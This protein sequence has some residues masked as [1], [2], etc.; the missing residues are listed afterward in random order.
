MRFL[1][2]VK[3]VLSALDNCQEGYENRSSFDLYWSET[4]IMDI[5]RY[6]INK[7][8]K[9]IKKE[10]NKKEAKTEKI[11]IIRQ[12]IIKHNDIFY[13]KK[14]G[15]SWELPEINCFYDCERTGNEDLVILNGRDLA[16]ALNGE[17]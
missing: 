12:I 11:A 16:D 15:Q 8:R 13:C 10:E 4:A 9:A 2:L 3:E 5:L 6:Q 7:L 1:D 14:C 17:D